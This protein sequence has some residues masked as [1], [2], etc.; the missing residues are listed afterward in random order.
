[1]M[2]GHA[3]SD[4]LVWSWHGTYPFSTKRRDISPH[5]IKSLRFSFYGMISYKLVVTKIFFTL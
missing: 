5:F 3:K 2:L 1:M 4:E